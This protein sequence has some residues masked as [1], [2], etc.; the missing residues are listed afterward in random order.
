M[1]TSETGSGK[2]LAYLAPLLDL[3]YRHPEPPHDDGLARPLGLVMA[4][5]RELVAQIRAVVEQLDPAV[6]QRCGC[7]WGLHRLN[8]RDRTTIVLATPQA[9][10][11][12]RLS[13]AG[14]ALLG[15]LATLPTSTST[16][17]CSTR[18]GLWSRTRQ[19]CCSRAVT[20]SIRSQY[21]AG[22]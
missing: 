6:A 14:G 11:K 12:A 8:P 13:V 15:D 2:T 20:R 18:C 16:R 4:P 22:C 19:T 1:V 10:E 17:A 5:T 21:C 7:A 9:A 3:A